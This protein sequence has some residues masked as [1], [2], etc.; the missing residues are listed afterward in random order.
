MLITGG[1]RINTGKQGR[2]WHTR[3]HYKTNDQPPAVFFVKVGML[4]A[5]TPTLVAQ[6]GPSVTGVSGRL[7]GSAPLQHAVIRSFI[8]ESIRRRARAVRLALLRQTRCPC[9]ATTPVCTIRAA[10]RALQATL[11]LQPPYTH[12]T[13]R[14][15]SQAARRLPKIIDEPGGIF[16]EH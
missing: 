8:R 10:Q 1:G 12:L 14:L 16:K 3:S 4:S 13:R 9:A 7:R 15:T 11:P 6:A 2:C 5:R